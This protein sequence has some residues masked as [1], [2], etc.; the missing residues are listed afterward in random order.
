M[1]NCLLGHSTVVFKSQLFLNGI[2]FLF[3]S[4]SVGNRE[5]GINFNYYK[6]LTQY[7]KNEKENRIILCKTLDNSNLVIAINEEF[8]K[9]KVF[10]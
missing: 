7:C 1:L 2:I 8:S 6:I 5:Q 3:S 10:I 9:R 4:Y